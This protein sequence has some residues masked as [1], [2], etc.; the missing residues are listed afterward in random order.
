[1]LLAIVVIAR[2]FSFMT[3][4][5]S[6]PGTAHPIRLSSITLV[7]H[8]R[9]GDFCWYL[10]SRG[11]IRRSPSFLP[12]RGNW[13]LCD[14]W[15][16][17]ARVAL[18]RSRVHRQLTLS[19]AHFAAFLANRCARS[20]SFITRD[21]FTRPLVHRKRTPTSADFAAFPARELTRRGSFR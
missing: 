1:M 5:V 20:G 7:F 16:W 14:W 9:F 12:R 15:L 11:H 8:R 10:R 4:P 6:S 21:A 18:T 19:S 3:D 13:R 2:S 17:D